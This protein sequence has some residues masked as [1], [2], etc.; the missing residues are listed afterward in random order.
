MRFG[1]A[2]P[3][4]AIGGIMVHALRCETLILKKGT[5]IG[6]NEANALICAGVR[7]VTVARLDQG[8][9]SEDAAANR[10]AQAVAG[11][12]INFERAITGRANL[13]A[14]E[15][16]L[17]VLDRT[18]VE[19]INLVDEAI[20][21]ATL[22]ALKP[23]VAN[24]MVATVKIIPF[25]AQ[26]T[27]C[28]SV[29]KIAKAGVIRVAPY[30]LKRVGVISTL[31]PGL[32]DKVID[33]T[34]RVTIERLAPT[35]ASLV[36][37]RRVPHD[38]AI[39]ATTLSEIIKIGVELIIV[40]GASA[41]ADRRDVIPAAITEIGGTIDHFGMPVDPGNLLMIS[42]V[43][44]IPVLGAP[45]CARSP[46][47][48]G[49]DW[50]LMRLLAD[51]AISRSDLVRMAVGGLLMKVVA[52]PQPA[53][54][55]VGRRQIG[56]VLLAAGQSSRTGGSN[57]MLVELMGKALIRI[58]AENAV[59]SHATSVIVVTGHRAAEVRGALEGLNVTFVHNPDY[60]EGLSG[61]IKT[62]IAAVP[63]DADGAIICPGNLPLI[64]TPLIN[65]LMEVYAPDRGHLI[66]AP[67]SDGRYGN[68]VLWS[69]QL[70]GELMTLNGDIG[71]RHLI[72]K[73]AKAVIDV[74]TEGRATFDD[75]DTALESE[76][77]TDEHEDANKTP[78]KFETSSPERHGV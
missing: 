34:L 69:R 73:H 66:A 77:D 51:I 29:V 31:L 78:H 76:S 64:D 48:N 16:G 6:P 74:P 44:D 67:I 40:F 5:L 20:T 17:L 45:G 46:V 2:N 1:P 28:N 9:L 23:V 12:G 10:I 18:T 54:L 50:V 65:R 30:R 49:F 35:G 13:F 11:D 55:D 59:A 37:E 24:E 19:D 47:E 27:S 7:E 25:G 56:V 14:K 39:L 72:V 3:E 68:P 4:D 8:D 36:V 53:A 61:S 43:G 70:F 21:L 60:A 63:A 71:A 57:K 38:Q 52:R 41:I 15:P 42:R 33:K 22:P 26:E 75:N 32:S 58:V 62:G